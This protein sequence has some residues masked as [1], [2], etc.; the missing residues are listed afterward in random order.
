MVK[1]KAK[2]A[3]IESVVLEEIMK[4]KM[5]VK[6]N[7][8]EMQWLYSQDWAYYDYGD[9]KRHLQIIFPY[10]PQMRK[11]EKF[12]LILFIPGSAWHKQEM[13]NDIPQYSLL[14]R[15]GFVFA[16]MEYRESD[17]AAFPA[18]IEDVYHALKFIPS[19]A[20]NF[21][22]DTT[23]I[24]LMGNSSGGHIA[25]MSV[26]FNAHG[27]CNTLPKISGVICESGSTDLLICAKEELPPWMK[28]RPSAVLLGVDKIEGHER[29]AEKASCSMYISENIELPPIL[30]MHSEYDPIVSVENSRTLYEKL[31]T[32]KHHVSYYELEG[33]DAHGGAVYYD[34][35]ILDIIQE[36]CKKCL[37]C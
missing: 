18:Q 29:L 27:L 21:H 4:Q 37:S 7:S 36:F 22:I 30:L 16:A 23:Q 9:C 13:Y 33:N 1:D 20:E 26:L 6:T 14:A 31:I 2:R 5:I 3:W 32:S 10:K 17:I 34:S 25:M 28:I 8:N 24:F 35:E 12:P 11:D 15:R 19:V